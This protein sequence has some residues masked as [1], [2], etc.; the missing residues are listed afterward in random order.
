MSYC[1][2]DYYIKTEQDVIFTVVPGT[3]YRLRFRHPG[4]DAVGLLPVGWPADYW[5]IFVQIPIENYAHHSSKL[6]SLLANKKTKK[7][8]KNLQPIINKYQ[9]L[10]I[11]NCNA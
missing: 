7:V 6:S 2:T 11:S 8:L 10:P 1:F 5:L 4:T 9:I 3:L